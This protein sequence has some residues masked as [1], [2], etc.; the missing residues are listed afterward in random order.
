ME[1]EKFSPGES[2]K[3]IQSMID[4]AKDTVADD[5]F[6]FLLWGW[7]VF[8]ASVSQY[9][10]KV[11]FHSPHHYYVWL[12]MIV[13]FVL[14][15]YYGFK[16]HRTRKVK[17]YV[18]ELMS[19]L[20]ISISF[21][22]ILFAFI[23][24]STGWDNCSPFFMSLYAIGTYIT[25]RALKFSPLV[26]GSVGSWILAAASTFVAPDTKILLGAVAIAIS[27]IVP[28]HLLRMKYKSHP[29]TT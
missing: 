19:Y 11:I 27:Y 20:W 7:L 6:Y 1:D 12:L 14:S 9:I 21:T 3:L 22:Y 8:A 28:G 5:S 24:S 13:G 2:L 10:L 29:K 15:I 17:T 18:E 16:G 25:G 4:K 23:F 26:W